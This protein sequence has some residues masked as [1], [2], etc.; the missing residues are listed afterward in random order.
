MSYESTSGLPQYQNI[1]SKTGI[2]YITVYQAINRFKPYEKQIYPQSTSEQIESSLGE[3]YATGIRE[4]A[5]NFNWFGE[6]ITEI[7]KK[8]ILRILN[9]YAY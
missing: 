3:A 1:S 2:K 8:C 4:L 6:V 5:K 9:E 7:G